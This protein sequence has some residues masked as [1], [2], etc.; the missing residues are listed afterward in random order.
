MYLKVVVKAG[1]RKERI[2][3]S[4]EVLHISVREAASGNLANKRVRALVALYKRVPET[5]VRLVS[6]HH[7]PIKKFS[8]REV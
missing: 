3:E 1:A 5:Q 7:S 4:G 8:V 2:E 6:G